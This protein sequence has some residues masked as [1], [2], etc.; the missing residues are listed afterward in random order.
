M[1]EGFQPPPH[2]LKRIRF[3]ASGCESQHPLFWPTALVPASQEPLV[4]SQL[5]GANGEWT[6]SDDV[7]DKPKAK[8]SGHVQ[9][10]K[11]ANYINQGNAHR[12]GNGYGPPPGLPAPVHPDNKDNPPKQAVKAKKAPPPPEDSAEFAFHANGKTA[13]IK[14]ALQV[15][16][17][18]RLLPADHV[19]RAGAAAGTYT[20]GKEHAEKTHA[21]NVRQL[22][23]DLRNEENASTL[24]LEEGLA[25]VKEELNFAR[26]RDQN[27]FRHLADTQDI[28]TE[29]ARHEQLGPIRR[30][31][32]QEAVQQVLNMG[33]AHRHNKLEES[34][35]NR[36]IRFEQFIHDERNHVARKRGELRMELELALD[37][38]VQDANDRLVKEQAAAYRRQLK[39][40]IALAND[41]FKVGQAKEGGQLKDTSRLTP[42]INFITN[43]RTGRVGTTWDDYVL[44]KLNEGKLG[45]AKYMAAVDQNL[46]PGMLLVKRRKITFWDWVG[47]GLVGAWKSVVK[48][49]VGPGRAVNFSIDPGNATRLYQ[50]PNRFLGDLDLLK[51]DDRRIC[52]SILSDYRFLG[53]ESAYIHRILTNS[54]GFLYTGGF[55]H[56]QPVLV[57]PSLYQLVLTHAI[58]SSI[59]KNMLASVARLFSD[60]WA[61]YIDM[62]TY[63]DT[64]NLACQHAAIF[65]F[66]RNTT[67]LKMDDVLG[68]Y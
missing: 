20:G 49:Q 2:T 8:A 12:G 10:G 17:A 6:G 56:T 9:G 59:T 1:Q 61:T 22:T 50:D 46:V 19:F 60:T 42:P 23:S 53:M 21:W 47:N 45:D 11:K 4:A 37:P 32:R 29:V 63:N 15:R 38:L 66:Q 7:D 51:R 62:T 26:L 36:V 41:E 54:E 55:T 25:E 16:V 13:G 52:R 65:N 34:R 64:I 58:G 33:V 39:D 18:D 27:Y 30:E 48:H 44:P 67:L 28:Q 5:S 14:G 35:T 68:D 31:R 43:P 24:R 3:Y 40:R 57:H